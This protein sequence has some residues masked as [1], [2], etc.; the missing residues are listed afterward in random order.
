MVNG[1]VTTRQRRSLVKEAARKK[2]G[3]EWWKCHPL[4]KK[5]RLAKATQ[6]LF[7][8]YPAGDNNGTVTVYDHG[9]VY[10]V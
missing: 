1:G 9:H 2:W 4:I 10:T 6:T 7:H 3:A 8:D 5:A